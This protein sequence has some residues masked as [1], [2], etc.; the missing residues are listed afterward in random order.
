MWCS[1]CTRDA[2][3]IG[4]LLA[5]AGTFSSAALAQNTRSACIEGSGD[6]GAAACEQALRS[7]P[8]DAELYGA[9][10]DRLIQAARVDEA[11]SI[12]RKGLSRF[13][14]HT[15]LQSRVAVIKSHVAEKKFLQ[16]RK[17]SRSS[18]PRSAAMARRDELKC[19]RSTGEAALTACNR[20]I[21]D[22]SSNTQVL[23]RKA[24]ILVQMG[25]HSQASE[26]LQVARQAGASESALLSVERLLASRKPTQ[27][28]ARKP[29]AQTTKPT[30]TTKPARVLA[31]VERKL[32]F[33]PRSGAF[34]LR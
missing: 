21:E 26:A 3:A 1:H 19:T 14:S 31:A 5:V 22:D 16:E 12:L 7:S 24:S 25:R 9:W 34:R 13:P 10:V 17:R 6:S 23:V 20:L 28:V 27:D 33:D 8:D 32:L 18:A 2:L 4:T 29:V 30:P 15:G 11:D